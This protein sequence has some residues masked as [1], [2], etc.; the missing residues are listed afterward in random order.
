M[1]DSSD[2][3]MTQHETG[4]GPTLTG[5]G[6]A[7]MVLDHMLENPDLFI[8]SNDAAPN[9][10]ATEHFASVLESLKELARK[11]AVS[12]MA[13]RHNLSALPVMGNRIPANPD[14]SDD[15]NQYEVRF[16]IVEQYGRD[17]PV[18]DEVYTYEEA[19][20]KYSKG[21]VEKYWGTLGEKCPS[22]VSTGQDRQIWFTAVRYPVTALQV[23]QAE[24]M[25]NLN[26]A[27]QPFG[28]TQEGKPQADEPS[29]TGQRQRSGYRAPSLK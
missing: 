20:A 4:P 12:S 19:C 11:V 23:D 6:L 7:D 17:A 22:L 13:N 15:P 29:S 8:L 28:A 5:E 18:Q 24:S 16:R 2:K 9:G 26:Q 14:E 25:D 10:N 27:I 1:T 3:T 21:F